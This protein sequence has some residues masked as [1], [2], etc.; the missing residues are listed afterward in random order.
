MWIYLFVAQMEVTEL[1]TRLIEQLRE[2]IEVREFVIK[3]MASGYAFLCTVIGSFFFIYRKDKKISDDKFNELTK[4][5]T[6]V[7]KENTKSN[8]EL[9][10]S[11]DINTKAVD[12]LPGV[13]MTSIKLAMKP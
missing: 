2:Q 1:I 3:A 8:V 12:N 5:L 11:I 10:S 9:R 6:Q 4:D 13:I 7:I